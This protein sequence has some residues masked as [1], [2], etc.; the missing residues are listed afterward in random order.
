MTASYQC[1]LR[2]F[3][4]LSLKYCACHE[5]VMPGHTSTAPVTQNHFPKTEDLM[6][7]NAPDLLTSLM[8]MSLV[9]RLP[10]EMHL[11]TSSA[12]VPHLPSLLEM[13]QNPNVLLAFGKVQNPSRLP[14]KTTSEPSKLVRACGAFNILTWKC[15]S[16]HN[17]VHFFDMSA[18][19][20]APTLVCFPCFDLEM[21]F[22][23]Q[24][25]PLFR[26]I[27]F[28]TCSDPGVLCTF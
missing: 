17:G 21:C 25:R 2:F 8:D 14:R 26:H 4:S 28:Q 7:Q 13:P 27:I 11:C 24:R 10:P 6:L 3:Q 23:P 20:S 1:V 22:A 9:L 19:K 18:S 12:N 16:R 15:A 5:K